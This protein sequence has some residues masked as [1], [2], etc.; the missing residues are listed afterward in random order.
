MMTHKHITIKDIYGE[1]FIK[2]TKNSSVIHG[3]RFSILSAN[4]V[5][6][7]LYFLTIISE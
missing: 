6:P 4:P 2:V 3:L 1:G 5:E 7:R